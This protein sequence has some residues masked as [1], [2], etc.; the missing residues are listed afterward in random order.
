MTYVRKSL[1][2]NKEA[3]RMEMTDETPSCFLQDL[4]TLP[5]GVVCGVAQLPARARTYNGG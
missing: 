3:K 1:R 5:R 4:K 2:L